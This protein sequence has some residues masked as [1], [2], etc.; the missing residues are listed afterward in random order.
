[1]LNDKQWEFIKGLKHVD[2]VPYFGEQRKFAD[3]QWENLQRLA[4]RPI[5]E[6]DK[7]I[8]YIVSRNG[9]IWFGVNY[10]DYGWMVRFGDGWIP[11]SDVSHFMPLPPTP[12]EGE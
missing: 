9:S 7:S 12:K 3:W 5:S 10:K 6:A 1:M 4:W 11:A 8:E 2:T